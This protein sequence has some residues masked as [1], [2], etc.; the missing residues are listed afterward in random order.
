MFRL[1]SRLPARTPPVVRK[2][3]LSQ[4]D[5][6]DLD[7]PLGEFIRY[8]PKKQTD[9]TKLLNQIVELARI[10][11]GASGAAIAFRGEHGTVC[12]A[13]AGK[14][15]PPVGARV[16]NTSG[17]SKQCLD[18]GTPILCDDVLHDARVDRDSSSAIGVRAMAVV[19]VYSAGDIAGILAVFS[20]TPSAFIDAHI[21]KL[22]RLAKLIDSAD[23][24]PVARRIEISKPSSQPEQYAAPGFLIQREPA[25]RSFLQNLFDVV[26]ADSRGPSTSLVEAHDWDKV[27]VDSDIAWTSFFQS[28]ALHFLAIGM[29]LGVSKFW[30]R[31]R[32]IFSP[33]F[34]AAD[35]IYYPT[36]P[37]RTSRRP[38][39]QA[40]LQRA[41]AR[42]NLL[43]NQASPAPIKVASG[44]RATR[45][46]GNNGLTAP[47]PQIPITST[48]ALQRLPMGDSNAV[49]P[50]PPT[51]GLRGRLADLP[52]SAVVAPSPELSG[53]PG[54]RRLDVQGVSIVPPAPKLGGSLGRS[55]DVAAGRLGGGP[56]G[57][58]GA[59]IVPPPPT[60]NEHPAL[61]HGS[62]G[63]A[64]SAG[65]QVIAPPPTVQSQGGFGTRG[66]S[67]GMGVGGSGVVP[68]PPSMQGKGGVGSGTRLGS[69]HGNGGIQVV[70]PSPS[71]SGQGDLGT[72]GRSI[73]LGGTGS[74]VVP[75]SPSVHGRG[76]GGTGRS[77]AFGGGGGGSDVVPPP[78]SMGGGTGNGVSGGGRGNALA[79]GGSGVVGPSP[80]VGSGSGAGGSLGGGRGNS[81]ASAGGGG[82]LPPSANAGPAPTPGGAAPPDI[83]P[84]TTQ[85]ARTPPRPTFQDA[86]LRVVSLAMSLP[87]TSYFSNYEVFV[88]EK[89]ISKSESQL[90]K[91]VYMFLPYQKR[92]SEYGDITKVFKVKV[93]R[94]P[95]C[96]ESLMQIMWPEGEKGGSAS[97]GQTQG[98]ASSPADRRNLLPC[99]R[100]T[101]DDYRRALSGKH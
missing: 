70:P 83:P 10:L 45:S 77:M 39:A 21:A 33:P 57:L 41:L 93:T 23:A 69:L 90:I 28:V 42:K 98:I 99:Y 55:T 37:S 32:L 80:S 20:A 46:G 53:A 68:P 65:V 62:A 40:N 63:D 92:L 60:V 36:F 78:P 59:A 25:L 52:S 72:G 47:A 7:S 96:D 79:G 14:G 1:T 95:T 61:T 81:L 22:Q 35:A 31:P 58:G 100:T 38:A 94:D 101:A 89:W 75:P 30:P 48:N 13:T 67:A 4:R 66:T 27:F 64:F 91:L 85:V 76:L 44:M 73:A 87:N 82:V 2:P 34:R 6:D 15:A 5:V 54:L 49:L 17:I 71:V 24:P 11:T 50:A 18:S 86:Q 56:D 19:P 74:G 12:G 88:A 8:L 97:S 16:D 26:S 84:S 3:V 9:F 43:R 29:L 51:D